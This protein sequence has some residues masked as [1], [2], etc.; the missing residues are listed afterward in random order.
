M[1]AFDLVGKRFGKLTVIR[2]TEN[3][4]SGSAQW[5]CRCDCGREKIATTS[6]LNSGHQMSCGCIA[7]HDL[8]GKR[9][10]MLIVLHE[11]IEG[12]K[13]RKRVLWICKCD[14]GNMTKSTTG[15]LER[16]LSSSCGCVRTKHMGKGTRLFRILTGM[17]DRCHNPNS[18]Y[19]NRYGARGIHVCDEW[20][21]DFSAFRSWALSTGYTNEMT[22]DRVDNDGPYSPE[23]C[24]W[25]TREENARK[26]N[27]SCN[28][29]AI[30]PN[31]QLSL[32]V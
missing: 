16:G 24:Q 25:L 5:V 14:C 18:K 20:R 11:Y 12:T 10:G 19:W 9:F 6:I 30:K 1:K 27:K 31:S 8:T 2:R 4:A 26:A 7:K 3:N 17:K 22:I 28:C 13:G 21:N 29:E 23:N 15:N 32:I